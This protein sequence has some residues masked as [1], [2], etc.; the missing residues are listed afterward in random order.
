[1]RRRSPW[2]PRRLTQFTAKA[3][4]NGQSGYESR[5]DTY[6]L[7]KLRGTGLAVNPPV[8]P[9]PHTAR[10]GRPEMQSSS[11]LRHHL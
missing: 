6:D 10:P 8:T 2:P 5:H 1:M 9:L 7:R 3:A 4:I 11:K